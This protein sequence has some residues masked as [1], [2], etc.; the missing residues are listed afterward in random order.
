MH[1]SED[2]S[3]VDTS[4]ANERL[5]RAE[6]IQCHTGGPASSESSFGAPKVYSTGAPT[7]FNA[8]GDFK[9][10][11]TDH[12]Y[13]HNVS[14]ISGIP[15]DTTLNLQPPGWDPNATGGGYGWGQIHGGDANWTTR[16]TCAGTYGCHGDHNQPTSLGGIGGSHHNNASGQLDTADS[17]GN[18]YRFLN[19]IKGYE[20]PEYNFNEDSDTHNEYFGRNDTGTD[21][22]DD[23]TPNY[24][25]FDTISFLCAECHGV[26]HGAIVLSGNGVTSPWTRHPTD[27]VLPSS[28]EYSDYNPDA[29]NDYNVTVPVARGAVPASS[30]ETV[31]PGNLSET[32]AIVMC[33]SCHRA[34]A[35]DQPDILRFTYDMDTDTTSSTHDG[36]FVCHTEKNPN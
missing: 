14:D 7:A 35:S 11:E 13:G 1:N 27:I 6:C 20:D 4:G 33:L 8:G 19:G 5:L 28:S 17:I 9:F 21:R 29:S 30:S 34:H 18:S 3:A 2:G 23:G 12:S 24:A 25:N 16:L 26:F 10:V 31:Q 36:C 22:D 32:G 15:Q